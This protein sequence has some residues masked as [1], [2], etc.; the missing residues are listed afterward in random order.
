[1]KYDDEEMENNKLIEFEEFPDGKKYIPSKNSYIKYIIREIDIII[2]VAYDLL[3]ELNNLESIVPVVY[4]NIEITDHPFLINFKFPKEASL[5]YEIAPKLDEIF[6]LIDWVNKEYPNLVVMDKK[7]N[8][9]QGK[10][11]KNDDEII[12]NRNISKRIKK[13]RWVI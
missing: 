1:M 11:D 2:R 9:I 10:L 12:D 5:I 13:I 4:D 8:I 6:K 7:G 3:N